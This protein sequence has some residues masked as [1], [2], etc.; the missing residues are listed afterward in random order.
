K[1]SFHQEVLLGTMGISG[2]LAQF[3]LYETQR[4][5]GEKRGRSSIGRRMSRVLFK[6][7]CIP[8]Y[9]PNGMVSRKTKMAARSGATSWFRPLDG[10]DSSAIPPLTHTRG[11]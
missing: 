11:L 8:F 3:V 4:R 7:S 10:L 9:F 1:C 6:M 2:R 5:R